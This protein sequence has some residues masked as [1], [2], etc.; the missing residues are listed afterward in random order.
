MNKWLFEVA[1]YLVKQA[2]ERALTDPAKRVEVIALAE[3]MIGEVQVF[4]IAL[5]D[6]KSEPVG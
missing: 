1:T 4:L 6:T 2:L 5:K 3:K